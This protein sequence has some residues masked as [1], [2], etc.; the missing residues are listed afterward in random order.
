MVTLVAVLI[1]ACADKGD[2]D[3]DMSRPATFG[4]QTSL[5]ESLIEEGKVTY[6]QYCI[7]CHGEAGNGQGEAALFLNPKPRNFVTAKFKFSSTR[8]GQLP[9]DDDLRRTIKYG[10]RGSAMPPFDLLPDRKV[11]ALVAY[12]KTFSPKWQEREAAPSVPFVV[13]PYSSVDDRAEAIARGEAVYHGFA[14]CWS[15]HP[16]YVNER[17]LS[18]YIVQFGG[19]ARDVFRPG[20]FESEGKANDEGEMVYPPDF[21]RDYVRAGMTVQDIYRSI[22]AGI[23]GTAMPTWVDSIDVPGQN[24]GDPPIVSQ[25][26]LWAMSYYVQSLITARPPLLAEAEAIVRTRPRPIYLHGAPPP[27]ATEAETTSQPEVDF[28]F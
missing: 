3:K 21:R 6:T 28:D 26:D 12:I 18:E 13:D 24:E 1:G 25:G 5:G 11:D 10:L 9:S 7:G 2:D 19:Q 16:A 15:C 17:K 8:S 4:F 22:A 20:L 27:S 14:N 23:S